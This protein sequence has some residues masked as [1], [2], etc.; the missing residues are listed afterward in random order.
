MSVE[1][2]FTLKGKVAFVTG[3]TGYLGKEMVYALGAAGAHIILNGRDESK[4]YTLTKDMEKAGLSVEGKVF[5]IT[6]ESHVADYFSKVSKLNILVNNAYEGGSGSIESSDLQNYRNSYEV[7]LISAVS[8]FKAALP[9]LHESVLKDKDASVINI[10]SMYGMV[11]PDLR[12]YNDQKSI[13]PAFYGASKAALIQWTRQAACE[14]GPHGIRVNSIS[15]GAFPNKMVQSKQND[16]IE[17][18]SNKIPLG[19]VGNADELCAPVVFLA[20]SG[21]SYVNGSNLVVDGG[22]TSW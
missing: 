8:L 5:D 19:R 13:N 17:K 15:P 10:A 18:L 14:Y 2:I 4:I 11:S 16:F 1:K 21:S 22:W 20:S 6:N 7:S 3:A 9:A 12:I